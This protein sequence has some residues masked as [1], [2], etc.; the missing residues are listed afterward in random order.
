MCCL[1]TSERKLQKKCLTQRKHTRYTR[2]HTH[3]YTHEP[4]L[5]LLLQQLDSDLP[6]VQDLLQF[7]IFLLCQLLFVRAETHED[8]SQLETPD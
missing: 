7:I 5:L 3:K 4:V 6:Q 2:T 8:A 1:L